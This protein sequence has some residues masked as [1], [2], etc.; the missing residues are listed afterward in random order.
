MNNGVT[1][2]GRALARNWSGYVDQRH[3]QRP[4]LC[5]RHD[6]WRRVSLAGQDRRDRR[7]RDHSRRGTRPGPDRQSR[8][9]HR[10]GEGQGARSAWLRCP[11]EM[12]LVAVG[13]A[14]STC[15]TGVSRCAARCPTAACSARSFTAACPRCA[16][17]AAGGGLTELVCAARYRA[18]PPVGRVPRRRTARPRRAGACGGTTP[19][20]SSAPAP[21]RR[22]R[23]RYRLVRRGPLR[24]H[25]DARH[26]GQRVGLRPAPAPQRHRARRTQLPRPRRR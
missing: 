2:Q 20:A 17:T 25:P 15:A 8:R 16:R 18:A 1:V 7:R 12:V 26:Q 11:L 5:A 3:D 10:H 24:R 6:W 21:Q 4:A 22:H 9:P 14:E 13:S 23:A 19:T